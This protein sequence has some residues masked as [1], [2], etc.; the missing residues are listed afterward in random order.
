MRA[1][2]DDSVSEIVRIDRDGPEIILDRHPQFDRIAQKR[3]AHQGGE[4]LNSLPKLDI[5]H[6]R[7]VLARKRRRARE[8]RSRLV[9]SHESRQQLSLQKRLLLHLP[10]HGIDIRADDHQPIVEIVHDA[11]PQPVDRLC[12]LRA[13]KRLFVSRTARC[14]TGHA[15]SPAKGHC[16][17]GTAL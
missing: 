4:R 6:M 12:L 17:L 7:R 11:V 10:R 16:P 9:R 14:D 1:Q 5:L 15:L 3:P 8:Q 13:A 2:S